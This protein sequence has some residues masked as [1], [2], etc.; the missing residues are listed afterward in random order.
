MVFWGYIS[1]SDSFEMKV[2]IANSNEQGQIGTF[3]ETEPM[4]QV[5]V[6]RVLFW[7]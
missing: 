6:S 3:P 1:A 5:S 2:T 7:V 4:Q